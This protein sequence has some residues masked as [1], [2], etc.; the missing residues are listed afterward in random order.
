VHGNPIYRSGPEK[1]KAKEDE[2]KAEENK[3]KAAK[4]YGVAKE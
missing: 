1:A 4:E 3:K 2:K